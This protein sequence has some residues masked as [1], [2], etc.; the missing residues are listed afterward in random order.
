MTLTAATAGAVGS[1]A[2][3]TGGISVRPP[4]TRGCEELLGDV[5]KEL[6]DVYGDD[7]VVYPGHGADTT[8][9]D[10]RPHIEEWRVR[11]VIGTTVGPK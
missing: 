3:G 8:L 5:T 6:F 10:E 7:T 2:G 11:L 1:A 9:G 4:V